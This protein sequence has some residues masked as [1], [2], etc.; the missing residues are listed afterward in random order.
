MK[1]VKSTRKNKPVSSIIQNNARDIVKSLTIEG[2][3]QLLDLV[4]DKGHLSLFIY[5][6]VDKLNVTTFEEFLKEYEQFK[7][8]NTKVINT[9]DKKLSDRLDILDKKVSDYITLNNKKVSDLET[10]HNNEV[11]SL[12]AR[13]E[14]LETPKETVKKASTL[15]EEPKEK[16]KEVETEVKKED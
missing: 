15:K 4:N 8:D 12:S 3:K 14:A 2:K 6:D 10:K 16:V 7:K 1:K 5:D 11:A 13:I 9:L